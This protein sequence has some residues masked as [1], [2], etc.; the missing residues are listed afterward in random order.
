VIPVPASLISQCRR[1]RKE[2]AVG[3]VI[4]I[5]QASF[6]DAVAQT[7]TACDAPISYQTSL[8][9]PMPP[10]KQKIVGAMLSIRQRRIPTVVR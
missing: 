8:I 2:T 3:A 9:S 7:K 6:L 5:R 10:R 4:P 1:A